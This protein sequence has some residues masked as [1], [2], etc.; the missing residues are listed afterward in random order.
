MVDKVMR[1]VVGELE[2][3]CIW[4]Q[5]FKY[6]QYVIYNTNLEVQGIHTVRWLSRGDAVQR[7][8]KVLCACIVLLYENNHKAYE[9]VMSFKF[10]FCLFFLADILA[11][12]N[13]SNR[14]FQKRELDVTEISKVVDHTTSDLQHRYLENEGQFGGEGK[15]WLVD[16]LQLYGHGGGTKVWV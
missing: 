1:T 2:R 12:M 8:C 4:G 9:I 3:S 15:C 10:Q 6:L 7:L 5:Q 14:C 11:D 16:F 13:D